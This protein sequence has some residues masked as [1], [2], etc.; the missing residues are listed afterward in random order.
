MIPL[1]GLVHHQ[2]LPMVRNLMAHRL[3]IL[4]VRRRHRQ[5][6]VHSHSLGTARRHRRDMARSHSQAMARRR[7]LQDSA[8]RRSR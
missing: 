7:H 3:L 8:H 1:S 4:M 5:D 2:A 6:M